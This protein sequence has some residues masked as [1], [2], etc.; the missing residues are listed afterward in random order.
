[1]SSSN[2]VSGSSNEERPMRDSGV[3]TD[4]N[5]PEY[6]KNT[7]SGYSPVSSP[8]ENDFGTIDRSSDTEYE[9]SIGD[10]ENYFEIENENED[11][12]SDWISNFLTPRTNDRNPIIISDDEDGTDETSEV[13]VLNTRNPLEEITVI[14]DDDSDDSEEPERNEV[15][16]KREII[17]VTDVTIKR[18]KLA[19]RGLEYIQHIVSNEE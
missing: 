16:E 14:S 1:M 4:C 18:L 5:D 3:C 12:E 17:Y 2:I 10:N 13:V 9:I 19:I 8:N 15:I 11:I 7:S 6:G